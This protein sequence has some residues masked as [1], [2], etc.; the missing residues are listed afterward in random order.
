MEVLFY[1]PSFVS[2]FHRFLRLA[3]CFPKGMLG[4]TNGFGDSFDHGFGH[5]SRRIE[6]FLRTSCLLN[7]SLQRPELSIAETGI[8]PQTVRLYDQT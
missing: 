1:F 5:N 7:A 2:V 6:D 3:V 4:I 8:T